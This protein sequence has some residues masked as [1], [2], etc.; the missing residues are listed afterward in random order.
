MRFNHGPRLAVLIAALAALGGRAASAALPRCGQIVVECDADVR[1]RWPDLADQ[2]REAFEMR[3]DIDSCARVRLTTI[4]TAIVLDVR[5][6]DGRTAAR[7]VLRGE[8]VVPALE[9][10]LLL[11]GAGARPQ[12][13]EPAAAP[14]S[15]PR[16]PANPTP[17]SETTLALRNPEVPGQQLGGDP[18]HFGVDL[19]IAVGAR[20]GDGQVGAGLRLVS[21]LELARWLVGFRGGLDRYQPTAGRPGAMAL[22]LG[23]LG[24]RRVHFAASTLDVVG[25]PALALRGM[26]SVTQEATGSAAISM[27]QMRSDPL[28]RLLASARLGFGHSPVHAFLEL[29]AE[30]GSPQADSD[31]TIPGAPHLPLWTVGI[32]VGAAVGTR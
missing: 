20:V 32:A 24:G 30:V 9:A 25:G 10:L 15:A 13:E 19:S 6:P 22:E 2:V 18:S 27:S 8:D 16:P 7:S 31:T 28:L 21:F 11:P 1:G 23:M 5:L 12:S 29:D 4:D 3:D 26:A 17:R 14:A